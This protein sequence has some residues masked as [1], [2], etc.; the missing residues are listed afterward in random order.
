MMKKI[1]II[2]LAFVFVG[3]NPVSDI[4]ER[5]A[6]E[7]DKLKEM[8]VTLNIKNDFPEVQVEVLEFF[9]FDDGNYEESFKIVEEITAEFDKNISVKRYH[10]PKSDTSF[11]V[12]EIAECARDQGR[13][14]AFRLDIFQNY[15]VDLSYA[16][17]IKI[18]EELG[19]DFNDFETCINSHIHA[20]KVASDKIFGEKIGV[21]ET[22]YFIIG[23]NYKFSKKV[24]E[25]TLRKL[26]QKLMQR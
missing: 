9:D 14:D 6:S 20:T 1:V 8:N 5:R 2:G 26:L 23:Q 11:R 10:F 7:D 17:L 3:C 21:K 4:K 19:L 25:K 22:P 13:F 16:N 12:A 24:P 18:S 15:S